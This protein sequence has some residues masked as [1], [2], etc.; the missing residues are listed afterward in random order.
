MK[1]AVILF[2]L[3]AALPLSASADSMILRR[4]DQGHPTTRQDVLDRCHTL[5][6]QYTGVIGGY[7]D[8]PNYQAA[9]RLESEGV[10]ACEDNEINVGETK[11][12]TALRELGVKPVE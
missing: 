2:L 12:R 8:H 7:Q 11:L 9:S 1:T 5:Q 3:S 10:S 6:R 4:N